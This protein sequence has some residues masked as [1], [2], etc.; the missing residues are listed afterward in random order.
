VTRNKEEIMSSHPAPATRAGTPRTKRA[1][2][3]PAGVPSTLP[4]E[5]AANDDKP[6]SVFSIY[7]DPLFG[8][9]IA[10]A[11]MFALLAALIAS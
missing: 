2:V 4:V 6:A 9:A 11:I 10:S 8:I 1:A 7:G 5:P 3:P